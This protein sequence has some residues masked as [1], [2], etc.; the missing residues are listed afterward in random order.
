M[1]SLDDFAKLAGRDH[2]LAV[3][4]T[5]RPD[6]TVRSSVVNA[7]VVEHPLR[8][9]PVVAFVSQGRARRLESLRARRQATVAL[10]AGWEWSAVEGSV[11]L[12]GPDDPLEGIDAERLRVLLREIFVAAGGSHDDWD[13]YDRVMAS[14]RRVAVIVDPARIYGN[15]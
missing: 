14:E 11:E 10:R 15:G 3:V 13:E 12:V 9:E 8:G 6:G 5:S 2:G 4:S 7:G 1:R